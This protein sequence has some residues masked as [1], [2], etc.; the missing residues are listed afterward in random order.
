MKVKVE[1]FPAT[2]QI[3]QC[4]AGKIPQDETSECDR[5]YTCIPV[6]VCLLSSYP[7]WR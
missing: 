2:G 5:L 3:C 6:Y 4:L 7:V 1:T